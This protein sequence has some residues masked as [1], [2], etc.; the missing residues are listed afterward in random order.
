MKSFNQKYKIVIYLYI[1]SSQISILLLL[2]LNLQK[3]HG[4]TPRSDKIQ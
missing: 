4:V 1:I 3:R 2:I